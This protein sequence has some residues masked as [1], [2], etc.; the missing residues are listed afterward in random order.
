MAGVKDYVH[1][2]NPEIKGNR[3]SEAENEKLKKELHLNPDDPMGRFQQQPVKEI[4]T[5]H[6]KSILDLK[7][8]RG[9]ESPPAD[10]FGTETGSFDESNL[11]DE[12]Q[13]DQDQRAQVI[14]SDGSTEADSQ[15]S[16]DERGQ[17][18]QNGQGQSSNPAGEQAVPP[19]S[20]KESL[21]HNVSKSYPSTTTDDSEP[22][23][24]LVR[25][26]MSQPFAID[27]LGVH[28]AFSRP[29]Q[30]HRGTQQQHH[31]VPAPQGAHRPTD[32]PVRGQGRASMD[33]SQQIPSQAPLASV[34]TTGTTLSMMQPN[35]ADSTKLATNAHISAMDSAKRKLCNI[36]GSETQLF[37]QERRDE[38]PSAYEASSRGASMGLH[39]AS[40]VAHTSRQP[41]MQVLSDVYH[42]G[43]GVRV[44]TWRAGS[45]RLNNDVQT[46]SPPPEQRPQSSQISA[47]PKRDKKRR[48]TAD[49]VTTDSPEQ[50]Q[51]QPLTRSPP[52]DKLDYDPD[53]LMK[54]EYPSL[55]T[56]AFDF[57]PAEDHA[58]YSS[59]EFSD[60]MSKHFASPPAEQSKFFATM[61]IDEWEDAGDWLL[62]R[63]TDIM[64]RMK[65]ARR[66]KRKLTL[67]IE[68]E[69]EKRHNAVV[70]KRKLTEEVLGAMKKSGGQ[71]L[72]ST[73]RK[74]GPNVKV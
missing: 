40:A 43:S 21:L 17:N 73:P 22:A 1:G 64:K 30:Q 36:Q 48:E 35:T 4:P 8:E 27:D 28:F 24:A 38:S 61:T 23:D 62:S 67:E 65:T 54:L 66:E 42:E 13:L 60:L 70:R 2:K 46:R 52:E 37:N 7:A 29:A 10:I 14:S 51:Q 58:P 41:V 9:H 39:H 72:A 26:S 32:M 45:P 18:M 25:P 15:V 55:R 50:Q 68:M 20:H 53:E 74:R 59:Q 11:D 69:I 19:R 3:R 56:Q 57:S 47:R 63:A 5:T 34:P 71:I 16:F 44:G 6:G 31:Q 33:R 49:E 12:T